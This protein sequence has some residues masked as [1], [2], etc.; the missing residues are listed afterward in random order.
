MADNVDITA[1]SGTV[2]ATEDLTINAVAAQVQQV[3]AVFGPLDTYTGQQGGRL[4]DGSATAAAGF[5]DPRPNAHDL[6]VTPTI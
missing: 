1:G 3:K 2:I 5:V 6:T 4:T